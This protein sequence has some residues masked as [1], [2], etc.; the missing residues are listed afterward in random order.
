MFLA[1]T[2]FIVKGHQILLVHNFKIKFI[3]SILFKLLKKITS[4]TLPFF[5]L[6]MFLL[7]FVDNIGW[8]GS[9]QQNYFE[10]IISKLNLHLNLSGMFAG[11]ESSIFETRLVFTHT[12]GTFE[13]RNS[14]QY[15]WPM[16]RS[17]SLFFEARMS[18]PQFMF[19]GEE[20]KK[21]MINFYCHEGVNGK[22]IEKI[23]MQ[24]AS[25]SI[26]EIIT[27]H[28]EIQSSMRQFQTLWTGQCWE[29]KNV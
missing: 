11:S 16:S 6:W 5:I 9:E 12:D 22:P 19:H 13:I 17:L 25:L 10:Q 18:N 15:R 20:L 4:L 3:E 21:G 1:A 29:S 2:N 28:G 27:S 26:S 7:F 23:E 8:I 24:G 14:R